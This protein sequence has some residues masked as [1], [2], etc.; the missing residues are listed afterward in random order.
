MS[1]L[2]IKKAVS[3]CAG[4]PADGDA[5]TIP[6]NFVG[7]LD[8]AVSGGALLGVAEDGL[9]QRLTAEVG[10]FAFSA[11]VMVAS[12]LAELRELAVRS[13]PDVIFLDSDFLGGKPLFE[14]LRQIANVAPVLVLASVNSQA[15]VA[16]LVA[17][18]NVEFIGR[19]GD[20]VS[21]A[22]ALMER[23]LRWARMPLSSSRSAW[24]PFFADIGELFRHEINNP[25]TGILGNAELVLA[26]RE[27]L[28]PVEV[29]RLQT[30]VDLAVRLRESIRRISNAWGEGPAPTN[31]A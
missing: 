8:A 29:Q 20:F 5:G 15:E 19:A 4:N 16:S 11:P 7:G 31:P 13:T 3:N 2:V 9:A 24:P 21:L 18:G 26:H 6:V 17:D 1:Q 22:A 25:L 10:R 27:H 28:S 14:P 12:S 30:V 23:R